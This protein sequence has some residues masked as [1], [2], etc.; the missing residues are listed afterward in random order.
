MGAIMIST[1]FDMGESSWAR[2][3]QWLM[4]M[5]CGI[6]N[7]HAFVEKGN[8]RSRRHVMGPTQSVMP[9]N[10]VYPTP[11]LPSVST[12]FQLP[13]GDLVHGCDSSSRHLS[14][15]LCALSTKQGEMMPHGPGTPPEAYPRH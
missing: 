15:V 8:D 5:D 2:Q 10:A 14:L 7:L 11:Y 3:Y 1:A 12:F 4:N 6:C 13:R 9:M